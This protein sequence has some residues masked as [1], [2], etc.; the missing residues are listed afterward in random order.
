M[1]PTLRVRLLVVLAALAAAGVVAGVVYATRQDPSQPKVACH[2]T[3][4]IVAGAPSRNVAAVRAAMTLKTRAAANALEPIAQTFPHDPVVLFNDALVLY[5]AGFVNEAATAFEQA[6]KAGQ[7]TY[8][9]VESDVLLHPQFFQQG[10]YPPFVYSGSDR[11]LIQGQV[12]QR[13]YH[14]QSAEQVWARDAELHPDSDVAQVAAAVGLFDMDDVTPAFSHLGPLVKQFPKS[15]SVRFH[16][17]LMLVWTGQANQA[18]VEFRAARKLGPSTA[19]G[20]QAAAFLA[21]LAPAGTKAPK[22]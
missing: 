4:K 15:Q 21:K 12:L 1:T 13:A 3:P 6:K 5:C 19:L 9:A 17:G 11:L 20:K 16:L 14:Q 10:G 18:L 7:D 22:R 8:Y 2:A